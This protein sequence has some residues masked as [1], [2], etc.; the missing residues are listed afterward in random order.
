MKCL[1]DFSVFIEDN[2]FSDTIKL[3]DLKRILKVKNY[4]GCN[5]INIQE[6]I[7]RNHWD[8]INVN[9]YIKN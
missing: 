9:K 7:Y 4:E 2:D 8:Q 3:F 5:V 6:T 1:Y